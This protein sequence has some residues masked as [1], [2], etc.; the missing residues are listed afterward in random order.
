MALE[1]LRVA[2]A[3]LSEE[4][5]TMATTAFHVSSASEIRTDAE[6]AAAGRDIAAL[7]DASHILRRR[8]KLLD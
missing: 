8:R 2:I 7:A 4:V 3:A 5:N 6:L 1:T